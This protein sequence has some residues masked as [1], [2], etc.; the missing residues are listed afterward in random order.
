MTRYAA[1]FFDL[2]DTLIRFDRERMPAIEIRGK[3]VRS[4]AG[5]LHAVLAPHAPGLTLERTW[6]A[7]VGSWQEAE[8]IRAIE[9]QEVA[10]PTRF[11]DFFRRLELGPE[12]RPP[13]LTQ[14]LL[15]THKRALAS[16]VEF[17]ARHRALLERL[18]VDHRLAVVSN[19]DYT[20]TAL[21]IL[22]AAGVRGLFAAIVVSDEIG[23][24]KPRA[25]IFTETL[26]R[27]GV[28]AEAT[29][30]VGDRVDIDVI[31]A[32]GVGMHAAWIN[33]DAAP[34][35]EG[36]GAPEYEIRDLLELEGILDGR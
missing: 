14:T 2:F 24:R 30:F 17:P 29:L 28:V 18:A 21:A 25:D 12:D 1:V 10:A 36:V 4:T 26:R 19:F 11:E 15:D 20:P 27:V 32:Q 13:G 31:G 6:D 34:L 8:R 3:R 7:L 33:P 16:A 23:W 35:P 22:D 9:H 5:R